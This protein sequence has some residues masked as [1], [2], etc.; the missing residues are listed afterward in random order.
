MIH[1][2]T[3]YDSDFCRGL[4]SIYKYKKDIKTAMKE[5]FNGDGYLSDERVYYELSNLNSVSFYGLTIND[6]YGFKDGLL[7]E[8]K[9]EDASQLRN[10]MI[11]D[12]YNLSASTKSAIGGFLNH[13]FIATDC[14]SSVN[15]SL[16]SVYSG[17]CNTFSKCRHLTDATF[18]IKKWYVNDSIFPIDL[19][20]FSFY[21]ASTSSIFYG[22]I[23]SSNNSKTNESFK[24]MLSGCDSLSSLSFPQQTVSQMKFLFLETVDHDTD[25]PN[26]FNEDHYNY[27]GLKFER[28]V[29][30]TVN[31]S[32]GSFEYSLNSYLNEVNDPT[33]TIAIYP[34][35]I[36]IPYTIVGSFKNSS[37]NKVE[38]VER[39][40][41][42]NT[43][44][45]IDA[46]AF[47]LTPVPES[48]YYV[49]NGYKN[50]KTID[51]KD[52]LKY[53]D[54]NS[55]MSLTNAVP[56]L[57][58]V[59]T[60]N[61]YAFLSIDNHTIARK[62]NLFENGT[63]IEELE[64]RKEMPPY[65]FYRCN[66][67]KRLSSASDLS[68]I[69]YGMFDYCENLSSLTL[70][71][72]VVSIKTNINNNIKEINIPSISSW[73]NISFEEKLLE[74]DTKLMLNGSVISSVTFP[75]NQRTIRKHVFDGY[76]YLTSVFAYQLDTIEEFAFCNCKNL[77]LAAS[78]NQASTVAGL[79]SL[80]APNAAVNVGRYAFANCTRLDYFPVRN[81]FSEIGAHAFENV[82]LNEDT[83]VDI[84]YGSDPRSLLIYSN[85][86][87]NF[88]FA[89]AS[90]DSCHIR[91]R[92]HSNKNY[93]NPTYCQIFENV[94]S[95]TQSSIDLQIIN[96][97]DAIT[98]A[99]VVKMGRYLNDSWYPWGLNESQ[100]HILNV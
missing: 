39:L 88:K 16:D 96:R 58:N 41:I 74:E 85:A 83:L 51:F 68:E 78:K 70:A 64:I 65:A 94:F 99:D 30:L 36:N 19:S 21:Q 35:N 50:L 24:N 2:L 81:L 86:F 12:R 32:D 14:I 52:T 89:K 4:S 46:N 72:S 15:V 40:K 82:T 7:F 23:V 25:D 97:G 3:E 20:A 31:C 42:G 62:W 6:I 5:R 77:K 28:S 93:T 98:Q 27:F 63:K 34:H 48:P 67:I 73:L 13:A 66:S 100:I 54:K 45:S 26:Y 33:K 60:E 49:E 91:L 11:P 37:I 29:P 44:L 75:E 69:D 90:T 76:S 87:S 56:M 9:C 17:F 80:N 59:N 55:K 84:G 8:K 38:D 53:I 92:V 71:E 18:N 10:F 47:G 61:A 95:G 79:G 43:V 57:S 1:S 22:N